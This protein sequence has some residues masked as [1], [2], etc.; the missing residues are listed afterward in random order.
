MG[1]RE[2]GWGGHTQVDIGELSGK[3]GEDESKA[4][5]T[6]KK[7]TNHRNPLVLK[8]DST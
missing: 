7:D 3:L 2:V 8:E 5:L 6:N 4:N 1:Q